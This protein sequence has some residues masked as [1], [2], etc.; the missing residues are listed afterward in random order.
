MKNY[1]KKII[2]IFMVLIILVVCLTI[3]NL[4]IYI[5]DFNNSSKINKEIKETASNK[6]IILYNKNECDSIIDFSNINNL[7]KES[8]AIAIVRIDS[9]SGSNFNSLKNEYVPVYTTG[10]LK[11]EKLIYNDSSYK[12]NEGDCIEYVRLGGEVTYSE[13]LKGLRETERK[14]IEYNVNQKTKMNSQQLAD[15]IVKDVYVNDIE[16]E[17]KKEYLVFLNYSN[18]YK[19]FNILGFEYGLREYDS[20]NNRIKNNINDKYEN[21]Q[22]IKEKISIVE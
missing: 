10:K 5:S 13:Y 2:R 12:I 8:D 1:N 4:I 20:V 15:K 14:K 17:E 7:V 21:F 11:V 3:L 22:V 9:Q 18:D 6:E 19:K 16:I